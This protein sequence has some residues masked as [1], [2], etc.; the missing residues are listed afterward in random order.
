VDGERQPLPATTER[1]HA[2]YVCVCGAVL[3]VSATA[4][5]ANT[6]KTRRLAGPCVWLHL[7]TQLI[8]LSCWSCCSISG[9]RPHCSPTGTGGRSQN[10]LLGR[11]I[12]AVRCCRKLLLTLFPWSQSSS[13]SYLIRP[14]LSYVSPGLL[15]CPAKKCHHDHANPETI[16][17]LWS[18][19]APTL[20]AVPLAK[21]TSDA[22][23]V[24]AD[25]PA[26]VPLL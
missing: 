2:H 11:L 15:C 12:G 14:H 25:V 19:A 23:I 5:V 9:I 18:S 6:G 8:L 21:A 10:W 1:S 16:A 22:T 26:A 13:G 3:W 17:A 20:E 7:V 24:A 4:N